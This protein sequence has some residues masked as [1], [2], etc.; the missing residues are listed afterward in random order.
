MDKS[1][2][3]TNVNQGEWV[4][5]HYIFHVMYRKKIVYDVMDNESV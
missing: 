2:S 4:V 5:V 3:E 1:K